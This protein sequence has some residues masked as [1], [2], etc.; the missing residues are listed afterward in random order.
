MTPD[1]VSLKNATV[2]SGS[3][4][5]ASKDLGRNEFL[6]L[7]M[8]QLSAQDPLNPM[9]S[10]EFTAQL[11]QFAS[12]EQLSNMGEKLDALVS[13]SGASNAAGAV[14]LLGK[15]VR[16][17]TN[18]IKEPGKVYYE[19]ASAATQVQLEVRTLDGRVVHTEAGLKGDKGLQ[20]V[21]LKGFEKGDYIVTLVA[22]DAAGKDVRGKV[23][24]LESVRAVNFQGN[25][26]IVMTN[27]GQQI[28]ANQVLEIRN[29]TQEEGEG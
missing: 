16:V 1:V 29:R 22:K 20:E 17:D 8:T 6:Q 7:L 28:P 26:P 27:S 18:T 4:A 12:L 9:D 14:S 5:P 21:D 25:V 19:L 23:S 10:S 11:S 13:I 24:V 2:T 15:E 3:A